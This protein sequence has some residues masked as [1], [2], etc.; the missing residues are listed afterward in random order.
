MTGVF[1]VKV[2][3]AHIFQDAL[4]KFNEHADGRT[5]DKSKPPGLVSPA[6]DNEFVFIP[7]QGEDVNWLQRTT[8]E[9]S[10][11]RLTAIR[12]HGSVMSMDPGARQLKHQVA[13][14]KGRSASHLIKVVMTKPYDVNIATNSANIIR[15]SLTVMVDVLTVT[16]F[17]CHF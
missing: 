9:L 14:V 8:T 1:S 10:F 5:S 6:N 13:G 2:A 3:G 7:H 12:T 16:D 11:V 4:S 15:N 17:I